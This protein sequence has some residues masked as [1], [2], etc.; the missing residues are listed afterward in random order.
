MVKREAASSLKPGRVRLL[1]ALPYAGR[2]LLLVGEYNR[3]VYP[4]QR[5]GKVTHALY[6][7]ARDLSDI[8]SKLIIHPLG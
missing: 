1:R 8:R 3:G 6:I 4:D 5:N 2:F 7:D